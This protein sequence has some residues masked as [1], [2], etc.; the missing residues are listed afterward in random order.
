MIRCG[1]LHPEHA[2][3]DEAQR[4]FLKDEPLPSADIRGKIVVIFMMNPLF[5]P[6]MIRKHSGE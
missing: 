3:N 2:P 1:F 4:A 5:M 6:M